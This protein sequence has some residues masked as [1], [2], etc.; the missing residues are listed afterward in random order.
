MELVKS[1]IGISPQFILALMFLIT[2]SQ[3]CRELGMQECTH[4]GKYLGHSFCHFSSKKIEF[5]G[6]IKKIGRKL[7]GWKQQSL[8]MAGRTILIKFVI[9]AIPSFTMQTFLIPHSVT[10][11]INTLMKNFF[12]GFN[13]EKKH[14][15]HLL[16]WKDIAKPKLQ[17]GT[18][19]RRMHDMNRA[20]ITKMNWHICTDGHKKWVKLIR[21]RYL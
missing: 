15:L 9:Q 18:G 2:W 4:N 10:K 5:N 21:A 6:L 7:A 1:S 12:W 17:G 14:H 11:K 20:M 3:I 8:S 16:S 19:I 13:R